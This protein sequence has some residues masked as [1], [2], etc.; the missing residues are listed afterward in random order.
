MNA[1]GWLLIT[2]L[3]DTA[4]RRMAKPLVDESSSGATDAQSKH[5]E[6]I[7]SKDSIRWPAYDPSL[8]TRH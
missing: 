4:S 3:I 7:M 8:S 5:E 1:N 6:H 2:I